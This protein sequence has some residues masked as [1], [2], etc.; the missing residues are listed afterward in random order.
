MIAQGFQRLG[1][2]PRNGPIELHC[3]R[4][5][6]GQ[7]DEQPF[8]DPR[9]HE[10]GGLHAHAIA[11]RVKLRKPN[12]EGTQCIGAFSSMPWASLA[13]RA[14]SPSRRSKRRLGARLRACS[15][16]P[17]A[18]WRVAKSGLQQA[19]YSRLPSSIVLQ[20]CTAPGSAETAARTS[21]DL[22][23]SAVR[24]SS[25]MMK[26]SRTPVDLANRAAASGNQVAMLSELTATFKRHGRVRLPVQ[27][28]RGG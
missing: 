23:R 2:K 6:R 11:A 7:F 20:T 26:S 28:Q 17:P 14:C 12:E 16:T 10:H 19:R 8:R 5:V 1:V 18:K 27:R 25:S 4:C 24:P 22:R 21:P 9:A 3:N 15:V 13:H